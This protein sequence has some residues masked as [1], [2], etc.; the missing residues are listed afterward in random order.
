MKI[1]LWNIDHPET[2][3]GTKSKETRFREVT[4]YLA[5]ADCDAFIADFRALDLPIIGLMCIPPFDENPGPH[6]A[7]LAQLAEKT[8]VEK[9]SMGMSADYDIAIQFGATHVR[10][11]SAIF[12]SRTYTTA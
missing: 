4:E 6:F 3:L 5:Q 2:G 10:V 7:L 1:G 8:G 11:G 12:G 9:L